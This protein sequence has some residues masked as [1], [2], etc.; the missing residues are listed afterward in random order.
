MLLGALWE[1]LIPS[2]PRASSQPLALD[3]SLRLVVLG[4]ASAGKYS[5][6]ECEASIVKLP[7]RKDVG[8]VYEH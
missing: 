4:D 5:G 3:T 2:S 1:E 7:F 8:S 6:P